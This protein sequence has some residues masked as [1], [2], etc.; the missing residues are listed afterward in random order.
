METFG[1]AIGVLVAGL[2][3]TLGLW[4]RASRR[5]NLLSAELE[6]ASGELTVLT[7]RCN[8]TQAEVSTAAQVLTDT[9]AKLRSLQSQLAQ[10]SVNRDELQQRLRPILDIEAERARLAMELAGHRTAFERD[11]EKAR[12]AADRQRRT[13]ESELVAARARAGEEIATAQEVARQAIGHA[14]SIAEA[15]LAAVRAENER[16]NTELRTLQDRAADLRLVVEELDETATLQ[17]FGYYHKRYI[18]GTSAQYE[19]LLEQICNEQKAMVRAKSA[20][21]CHV[22]WLVNGSKTEGRKQI[23]QTLKLMLRAFNGEADAAIAQVTYKNMAVMEK[24]I[25]KAFEAINGMAEIQQCRIAP[26]Y[27]DLRLQELVL[28][29]EHQEKL[30]EE[31]QE[32]RRIRERMR[33]EEIARRK[34][35]K[36]TQEA[37]EDERQ[38][39]EALDRARQEAETAHGLKQARLATK[40]AELERRLEEAHENKERAVARA[41]LTRSGH[42]YV[43][44]NIGSFGEHVYKIGMTRRLDPLERIQEL[45]DASVPFEFDIHA[46][47]FAEDAPALETALHRAFAERRVNRVNE[48]KEFFKVSIDDIAAEVR[49]HRAEIMITMAAEAEDYRKTVAVLAELEARGPLIQ[50]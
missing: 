29:H 22:E 27:L 21:A 19:A 11:L 30:H 48:R 26:A 49:K 33:D 18:F 37:E 12:A 32:Q 17:S 50:G 2:V 28:V 13:V 24:R 15:E 46:V 44:S 41:Q 16:L 34:I 10:V 6:R 40:V 7:T 3:L 25:Q 20:A 43:I 14:R 47:I 1:V 45:G 4:Y 39:Q 42:V 38:Y 35:E 8:A 31:R 23:N 36:A 5:A 9:Q